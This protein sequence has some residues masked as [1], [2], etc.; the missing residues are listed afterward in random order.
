MTIARHVL[1]LNGSPKPGASSSRA[2]GGYVLGR[3]VE[4][5]FDTASLH[6]HTAVRTDEGRQQL[7][8]AVDGADTIV[9][10]SPLYVDSLPAPTIRALEIIGAHRQG[11][12]NPTAPAMIA[13]VN[14]G[15]PEPAQS[16]TALAICRLFARASRMQWLGGLPIGG[17]GMIGGR[18]VRDVRPKLTRLIKALDLTATAI[19][20]RHPLP[21]EVAKLLSRPPVPARFYSAIADLGFRQEVRRKGLKDRL[22]NQPYLK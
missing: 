11:L 5:G 14:S 3:L 16:L 21:D 10:A 1:F 2:L 12:S 13:I 20:E 7:I 22:M 8:A 6:L 4:S 19:V 15:F 18:P 17:G 9:L